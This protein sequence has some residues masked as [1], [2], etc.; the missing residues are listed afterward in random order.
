MQ[1]IEHPETLRQAA[2]ALGIGETVPEWFA[3]VQREG[4]GLGIWTGEWGEE[5]FVAG[6]RGGAFTVSVYAPDPRTAFE[7]WAD[8]Y[9]DGSHVVHESLEI[10]FGNALIEQ[11]IR[12]RERLAECAADPDEHGDG[13]TPWSFE[14]WQKVAFPDEIPDGSAVRTGP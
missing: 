5:G 7:T 4:W 8:A 3:F 13:E 11:V 6:E 14:R 2:K 1:T 10:A 9:A 12:F